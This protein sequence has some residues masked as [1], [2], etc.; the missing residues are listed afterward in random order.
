MY[1]LWS[2]NLT[3][4]VV[5]SPVVDASGRLYVVAEDTLWC[6]NVHDGGVEW[7]FRPE[8]GGEVGDPVLRILW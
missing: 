2:A 1:P 8:G 4:P 6:F 7:S 3:A 5:G